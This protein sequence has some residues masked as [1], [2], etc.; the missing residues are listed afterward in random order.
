MSDAKAKILLVDNFQENI[1]AMSK[2][3]ADDEMEI[4]SFLHFNEALASLTINDYALAIFDVQMTGMSG[5]ELS[6]N[7]RAIKNYAY[8]PII[9]ITSQQNNDATVLEGYETGA[10]DLLFKP[11]NPYILKSKVKVFVELK[12]QR[13]LMQVQLHELEIL[14]VRAE[15]ATV[16]KDQFL[17]NMSHEIRTPLAAVMGFA[18]MLARGE[19]PAAETDECAASI[20][21]NGNLLIRLIDDILDLSMIEA[22]RLEMEI[23]NHSLKEL[24]TDIE[25]TLAFK[26]REKGIELQFHKPTFHKMGHLFDPIRMKQIFLNIIGNA[27]KF[28][29][30]GEVIVEVEITAKDDKHDLLSVIVTNEGEG[31]SIEQ[32]SRLFQPFGQADA[33]VK[34]KFG[35][36]GL[37]L[38]IS[39]QLARVMKGDVILLN[40]GG[41]G[42]KFQITAILERSKFSNE[43]LELKRSSFEA[44]KL[45]MTFPGKRLLIVDDARDN[46]VLL[47]LFLRGTEMKITTAVNG[48]DAVELT[49]QNKYDMILMDIHMPVMDGLEATEIIRRSGIKIPILALTA[50]ANK[51][52][53][54]KCRTAGCNDALIKPLSKN[55]LL[56]TIS[57]FLNQ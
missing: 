28:S 5:V 33:T 45:T 37:G 11:I 48:L 52:E 55:S 42:A 44:E 8:L 31:I 27:I 41:T 54:E 17:A 53:Y 6:K 2:I 13:Q 38:V 36:S 9:F 19:I 1:E 16:A 26:A 20:R 46:L 50:Y 32:A 43:A 15:A 47:D 7:I 3:L 40:A 49:K 30:R 14:R 56:K 35:G 22:N 18:D 34:R 4:H 51:T 10:V 29:H 23:E 57:Y 24:M 21:R 12:R 39:R 25:S